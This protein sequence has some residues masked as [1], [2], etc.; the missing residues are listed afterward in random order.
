MASESETAVWLDYPHADSDDHHTVEGTVKRLEALWSPQLENER[1]ILVY[2]PPS[3]GSGERRYP[4][5]YMHD[6]QNLFDQATSFAG[7]WHVDGTMEMLGQRGIEAIVVAIPNMGSARLDEYSPFRDPKMGGGKGDLYLDF[8]VETLKP[9]IDRDFRTHPDRI[10]TCIAGSSM[11]GLISLYAF[12]RNADVFGVAGVMSPAL[13]FAE[14]AIF[15]YVEEASF[16][17]GK[18][19]LDI[20][21]REGQQTVANVRRLRDMLTRKGYRLRRDLFYVEESGAGHEEAAWRRR[22]RF[23]VPFFLRRRRR[24]T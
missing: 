19:Y 2:L 16:S 1:E 18:L 12:F 8:V 3:Y 6:G 17:A 20:G 15:G 11:G 13:W 10:H 5:L 7:E 14:G 4:V 23:A 24:T 22:I 9:I 21:T